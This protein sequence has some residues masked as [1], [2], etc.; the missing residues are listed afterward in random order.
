[1]IEIKTNVFYTLI[2]EPKQTTKV[3]N[4]KKK[5]TVNWI[6]SQWTKLCAIKP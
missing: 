2:S 3:V 6:Y 4:F 1:M 5:K